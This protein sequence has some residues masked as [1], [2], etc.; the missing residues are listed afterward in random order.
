MI[1]VVHDG[2]KRFITAFHNGQ[3]RK[4]VAKELF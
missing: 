2:H 1:M 4:D 3:D